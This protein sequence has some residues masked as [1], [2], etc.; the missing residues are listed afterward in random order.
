MSVFVFEGV[1]LADNKSV[2]RRL[3]LSQCIVLLKKGVYD[4]D[5]I[6]NVCYLV[7]CHIL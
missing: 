1:Q 7:K 5:I 3:C 4:T 2:W 6:C